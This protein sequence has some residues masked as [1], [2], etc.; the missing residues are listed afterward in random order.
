M[1]RPARRGSHG[2]TLMELLIALTIVAL[3][4]AVALPSYQ[5][6]ICKVRRAEGKSALLRLMQQQEQVYT[7]RISYVAF[8]ASSLGPDGQLFKWFSGTS[9]ATSSYEIEGVACQGS[10]I[11]N[12]VLLVAHPGTAQV[13]RNFSDPACGALRL[14]SEGRTGADGNGCW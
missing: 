6:A 2:F 9:P 11:A 14:D 3:L 4:A 10:H 12:C 5:S 8:S 13:N 7:Q 1:I